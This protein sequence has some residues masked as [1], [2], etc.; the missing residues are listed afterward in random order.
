MIDFTSCLSE[1]LGFLGTR[2]EALSRDYARIWRTTPAGPFNPD[3]LYSTP[4]KKQVERELSALISRLSAEK[5]KLNPDGRSWEQGELEKFAESLRP[6]F[7]SLLARL[8]LRLDAVYDSRFVESTRQFLR[9]ARDFDPEIG[10]ASVYQ[11]LRNVWIMNTLQFYLG[12]KV[13][14]TDAIFGYS[15]VYP[16]L[17]NFLDDER[18]AESEKLSLV[19]RLKGWLEGVDRRAETPREQKLHVLISTIERQYP[20]G[21]F[22]G[23]FQSMLAILNAQIK[24]LLQQREANPP[25]PAGILAISLEKGGT[26][27][28]ADGYLVAGNLEPEEQDFCF[29]FGTFLQLA[30]DLQDVQEDLGHGHRTVFSCAAGKSPL[31]P[32]VYRL[33]R[34]VSAVVERTLGKSRA[35]EQA[36]LKEVIPQSCVLMYMESVGKHPFFFSKS[37]VRGFQKAFPVRFSYLRKLRRALPDTLLTGREKIRELDPLSAALMAVSSRAFTLD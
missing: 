31:D 34:Y 2:V 1:R 22:P 15:M 8:G 10:I 32:L 23:V 18:E 12:K 6:F 5:K 27:V 28:L 19:R 9:T 16:Y 37:C 20:R 36:A 30:D 24:S 35:Q 14:P 25:D 17:D 13:E 7:K 3:R 29:G 21:S 26:S 11:A 4:E 33:C